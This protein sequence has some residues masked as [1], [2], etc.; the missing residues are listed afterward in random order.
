MLP[1]SYQVKQINVG[2]VIDIFT[3]KLP[4]SKVFS[5]GSVS[6]TNSAMGQW[7]PQADSACQTGLESTFQ[8]F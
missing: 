4:S 5:T 6:T 1:F 7:I 3:H 2:G 8:M